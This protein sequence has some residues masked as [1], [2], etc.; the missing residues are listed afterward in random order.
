MTNQNPGWPFRDA[1]DGHYRAYRKRT[2]E[3]NEKVAERLGVA[4]D[5]LNG[6]RRTKGSRTPPPKVLVEAAR[7]F[8]CSIHDLM[9]NYLSVSDVATDQTSATEMDRYRIS[10]ATLMLLNPS[11]S[12][13]ERDILLESM[14]RCEDLIRRV[15][16]SVAN[17]GKHHG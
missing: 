7:I 9:P 16:Q 5:T 15:K 14:Q 8:G 4:V 10:A 13:S 6:Y 11:F 12:Q 2:G 17:Q 3:T 1:F